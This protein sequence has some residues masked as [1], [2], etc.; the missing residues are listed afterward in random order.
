M[1]SV[2]IRSFFWP[3]FSFIRIEYGDLVRIFLCSVRIQENT[4]Q[5]KTRQFS[6]SARW[7][8]D[9]NYGKRHA[10]C[11]RGIWKW[12]QTEL[13]KVGD[14]FKVL[15]SKIIQNSL[16]CNKIVEVHCS[17]IIRFWDFFDGKFFSL[18]HLSEKF[19]NKQVTRSGDSL[20]AFPHLFFLTGSY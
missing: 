12:T 8:L 11:Q 18:S 16:S 6:R 7:F 4:D 20:N 19:S 9:I 17:F 5:K 1:R 10:A 2:Q 13:C 15:V 3:V 14:Y